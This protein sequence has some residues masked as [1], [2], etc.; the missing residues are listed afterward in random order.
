[1]LE[2]R[3]LAGVIKA[4]D[5]NA[6]V[7]LV[8]SLTSGFIQATNRRVSSTD[9]GGRA[10]GLHGVL[11]VGHGTD[12]SD[13]SSHVIVRNSWGVDWAAAGYCLV[14]LPYLELRLLEAFLL[15]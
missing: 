9:A 1:M 10:L 7:V 5:A 15:N 6:P 14:A 11:A 2:S 13:G 12:E 8:I 4:L 3:P